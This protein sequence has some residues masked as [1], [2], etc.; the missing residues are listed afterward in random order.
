MAIQV[1]S[2]IKESTQL[3]KVRV[4]LTS[5]TPIITPEYFVLHDPTVKQEVIGLAGLPSTTVF[6]SALL[7][8][9]GY[10]GSTYFY[11]ML[12]TLDPLPVT[13]TSHFHDS[14]TLFHPLREAYR[15]GPYIDLDPSMGP[16]EIYALTPNTVDYLRIHQGALNLFYVRKNGT[17]S[18][19]AHIEYATDTT[20]DI[21]S[22]DNGVTL[23]RPR[24]L[25]VGRDTWTARNGYFGTS[26]KSPEYLFFPRASNPD[27]RPAER[28]LY[29]NSTDNKPHVWNGL[30]DYP[31]NS[32]DDCDGVVGLY[33][34]PT[35][36]IGD[37]VA[38]SGLNAVIQAD[39]SVSWHNP[40][41]GI[42]VD[43]PTPLVALVQF[44]GEVTVF[45]ATLTPGAKYF[46][47]KTAGGLTTDVSA[48]VTGDI[49]QFVGVGKTDS[50]LTISIGARTIL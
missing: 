18:I 21:G 15:D 39:A 5:V 34:G 12:I 22:V 6:V 2:T 37:A 38:M 46:L 7:L 35:V 28:H 27:N 49:V 48:F 40:V 50:T 32:C 33:D 20:Y 43:K 13:A 47:D 10:V 9:E 14:S 31:L 36:N 24:D 42:C 44:N 30:L 23:R 3:Y 29:W 11:D 45:P 19:G 41:V 4:N 1:T 26:A 17:I 16:V 25:Y 8:S